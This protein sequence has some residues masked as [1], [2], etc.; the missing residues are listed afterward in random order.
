[1][2]GDPLR[3]TFAQPPVGLRRTIP[4]LTGIRGVAALLVVLF[5][6]PLATLYSLPGEVPVIR[7]GTYGVEMFFILSGFILLHVH[8]GDFE[9]PTFPALRQ[10]AL[11]RFFR[12]Y[13]LHVGVLLCIVVFVFMA[14]GYVAWF[15][16]IPTFEDTFSP[17]GFFQ[18]LTLTN[19]IGLPS[20]GD[21]NP[22]SWSLSSEVVGYATFPVLAHLATKVRSLSLCFLSAIG[23]LTVYCVVRMAFS[24]EGSVIRMALCFSAGVAL[25]RAYHLRPVVRFSSSLAATCGL[26]SVTALAFDKTAAFSVFGFAG[27][28]YA[29]ALGG[30]TLER[31]LASAPVMFL[32]TISFSL[33][34]VHFI[35]Q[36]ALLW[37]FW[38]GDGYTEYPTLSLLILLGLNLGVATLFYYLIERPSHQFGRRVA[39]RHAY[40]PASWAPKLPS[41]N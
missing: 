7:N 32:G 25:A 22:P 4:A 8:S 36:T 33:Y 39:K 20:L 12:I 30:G 29:L 5:H 40:P 38:G 27:L 17:A 19:R 21:W 26:L 14:P 11:T 34:L 1:M 10:F 31:F 41:G 3:K 37:A 23:L 28:I 15:R 2:V 13:P 24:Y 6:L 35:L 9:R 16:T 18:T